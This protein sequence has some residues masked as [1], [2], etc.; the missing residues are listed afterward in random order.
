MVNQ[1]TGRSRILWVSAWDRE[2]SREWL[3]GAV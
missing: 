1:A 3:A 2:V